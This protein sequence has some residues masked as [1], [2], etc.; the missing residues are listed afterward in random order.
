MCFFGEFPQKQRVKKAQNVILHTKLC[1]RFLRSKAPVFQTNRNFCRP[2]KNKTCQKK[3]ISIVFGTLLAKKKNL[4]K[5]KCLF[6]YTLL[7]ACFQR[8]VSSLVFASL[9]EDK[10]AKKTSNFLKLWQN[11]AKTTLKKLT[12]PPMTNHNIY[13]SPAIQLTKSSIQPR[14]CKSQ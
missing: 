12:E 1:H 14:R 5:H 3:L 6:S 9:F 4:S 7:C 10:I 2:Y 13:L 11:F 8:I